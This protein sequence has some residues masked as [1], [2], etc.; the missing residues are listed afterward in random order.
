MGESDLS[1][2]DKKYIE[3][4]TEF[5]N[6]FLGQGKFENRT[7]EETLDLALEVL[8]ILPREELDKLEQ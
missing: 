6:K 5:E 3:F 7:I 8:K 2:T 1:E 4:G